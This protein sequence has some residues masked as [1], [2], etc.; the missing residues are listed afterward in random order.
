MEGSWA[1]LYIFICFLRAN[2]FHGLPSYKI[3]SHVTLIYELL[4]AHLHTN[5]NRIYC[6]LI[7]Y[8]TLELKQCSHFFIQDLQLDNGGLLF[9]FFLVF[10]G[11][12]VSSAL[13]I[14]NKWERNQLNT[15]EFLKL[16][17][18]CQG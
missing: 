6:Q 3:F 10:F 2:F 7:F 5:C 15:I 8:T 18:N 14:K 17:E 13:I 9:F 16:K 1:G 4:L 12:Q 11:G